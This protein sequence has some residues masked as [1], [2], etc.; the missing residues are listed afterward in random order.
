MERLAQGCRRI[1]ELC[2]PAVHAQGAWIVAILGAPWAR[3]AT[4][5]GTN[6][7]AG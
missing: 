5:R 4:A 6:S 2:R 1:E 7:H 3:V